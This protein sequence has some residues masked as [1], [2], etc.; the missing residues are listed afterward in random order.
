[1]PHRVYI[2]ATYV[3][4]TCDERERGVVPLC[5]EDRGRGLEEEGLG[6]NGLYLDS[7]STK[8][9]SSAI[10]WLTAASEGP[11]RLSPVRRCQCARNGTRGSI[12]TKGFLHPSWPRVSEY[13]PGCCDTLRVVTNRT[14]PAIRRWTLDACTFCR[15]IY[16]L[17]GFGFGRGDG[18]IFGFEFWSKEKNVVVTIWWYTYQWVELN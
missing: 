14:L 9:S 16:D 2:R 15:L 18:T 17:R 12:I 8:P 11:S 13:L 3:T 10:L 5:E 6:C 1:M 7:R 4:G